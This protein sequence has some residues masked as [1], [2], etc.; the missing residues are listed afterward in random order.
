MQTD[1]LLITPPFT[2]LN[3]PYPALPYLTA[4]LK[5]KNFDVHQIDLSLELFLKLFNTNELKNIFSLFSN[6][7]N[8]NTDSKTEFVIA[9][10]EKYIKD[11][12]FV[13]NFM[14]N[15]T[16][17]IAYKIS[18]HKMLVIYSES[19]NQEDLDWSFGDMGVIDK[20]K[21]LCTLF[22]GDIGYFI[23]NCITPF[24]GFSKYAESLS[25]SAISF[26]NIYNSLIEKP[27]IIDDIYLELLDEKVKQNNPKLVAFTIPFPG[28]VY[29]AFRAA[30][31]IKEKYSHIKIAIGGGFINTELRELK[32]KRVFEFIDFITFDNGELPLELL[33]NHL[34]NNTNIFKRTLIFEQNE[35]IFKDNSEKL[36]YSIN[37]LSPPSY[38]G[39]H[40]HKYISVID[41][42][43]PMHSLWSNGRWNKIAIA[44]GCY[45]ANCTFCDTSLDYI[46][47]F[48]PTKVETLIRKI[49][50]IINQTSETGFHF[51]DEA[52][53]PKLL[54]ELS[55]ELIR[56][57]INIQWWANIRFERYFNEN[58][59]KLLYKSGCIAV[60][61]GI[62]V[63]SDRILKLINKGVTV[64]QAILSLHNFHNA[65]IMTHA[66]LMYGF[67]SQTKL[68]TI[69]SLEVVRQMFEIGILNSAFWHKFTLTKHSPIYK[70]PET[71]KIKV[72][73]KESKIFANNDVAHED[74]TGCNHDELGEG[75]KIALYNYMKGVGF[76]IPLFEWF[77]TKV[78]NTTLPPNYVENIIK[79]HNKTI[80]TNNNAEYYSWMGAKPLLKRNFKNNIESF[81]L[82]YDA[83]NKQ[84]LLKIN[85]EEH[86]FLFNLFESIDKYG[87]LKIKDD[88]TIENAI[89]QNS[90]LLNLLY[91]IGL[92]NF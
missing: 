41:M 64:E 8:I 80:Q 74:I 60:T 29:A 6:N 45:W 19:I 67:P 49:E 44:N 77:D 40:L 70:N 48:E 39:L 87:V 34:K 7:Q 18:Q 31:F 75:L 88:K 61:G 24:F 17:P 42:L 3:T 14:Q 35:I 78:P 57:D 46:C 84:N 52:A 36:D 58:I 1:I 51:V 15:P 59:A 89:L 53:P 50:S 66:Y 65:G 63:A 32:D 72:L 54:K 16:T 25:L 28:N 13:I 20:A 76:D 38:E 4:H 21:H 47:R 10:K 73:D 62:E 86:D 11:V 27:N 23:K 26:D 5:N 68:E 85:K 33:I 2:Q 30:K 12:D 9:N 83:N 82:K 71:F 81:E 79:K 37:E 92:I 90:K 91:K 43:N 69:N 22:I 55:I 56:K